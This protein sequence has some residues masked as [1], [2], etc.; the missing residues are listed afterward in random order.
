MALHGNAFNPDTGKL[1]EYHDLSQCSDGP[2]WV[3]ANGDEIGRL[4]QG[5]GTRVKGTDTM[6]FI[7][8]QDVPKHKKVTYVNIVV[9]HRPEKVDPHRVRWTV[10]GNLIEYGGD[11][12]T[13]TADMTVVKVFFNSVLSTPNAAFMTIDIKNFYLG[14]PMD[15]FEYMRI[16]VHLIPEDIMRQYNL[17]ELVHNGYVYV[18]IQKG[19]YG[20]PQAGR[21]A[22]DRLV[23]LLG[24]HGY[25]PVPLTPGLWKHDT[26]SITFKLVVDDFGVKYTNRA[27]V[28][29]LL[30]A[31]KENYEVTEDWSGSRYCGLTVAWDYLKCTCDISMPG[32]V[33]RALQRFQHPAP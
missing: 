22:N 29:H 31:L 8:Y 15:E 32:Y 14:T 12:S 24:K 13:K 5:R 17:Y 7:R 33:E 20:L 10:G 1:A 9:A 2:L 21:L 3:N 11:V 6:F 30:S 16:A 23:K 27:D 4:C 28:D 26:N 19:M 18:E 25:R